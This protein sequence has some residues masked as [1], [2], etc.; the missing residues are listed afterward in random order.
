MGAAYEQAKKTS[1][2]DSAESIGDC[3]Y[4]A[5]PQPTNMKLFL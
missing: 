4:D 3:V 1:R 2:G 5:Y